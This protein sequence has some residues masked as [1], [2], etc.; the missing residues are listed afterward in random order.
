MPE[1]L[2]Q[3][4]RGLVEDG[5]PWT[6]E[7]KL[8]QWL[9]LA[10]ALHPDE[11]EE[12]NETEDDREDMRQKRRVWVD[13]VV[14]RFAALHHFFDRFHENSQAAMDEVNDD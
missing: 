6:E 1:V 13:A 5:T 3:V 11:F 2:R 7:G 10:K 12:W 8:G 14:A 4:L 9:R